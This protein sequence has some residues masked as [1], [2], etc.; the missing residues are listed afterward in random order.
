MT[1]EIRKAQK[2]RH[3]NLELKSKDT[4]FAADNLVISSTEAQNEDNYRY[5]ASL[6]PEQRLELHYRMITC[7][8]AKELKES[9]PYNEQP[10]VF[11]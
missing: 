7:I 3:A 2:N 4:F 9:K 1:K 10:V 6:S 11:D 5:W 8:Y